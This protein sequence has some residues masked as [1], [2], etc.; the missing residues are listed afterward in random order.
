MPLVEKFKSIKCWSEKYEYLVYLGRKQQKK[1][2]DL[3]S[4]IKSFECESDM[5]YRISQLEK[6]LYIDAV[7]SSTIISGIVFLVINSMPVQEDFLIKLELINKISV[8]RYA[9]L[10]S[11]L[12]KIVSAQDRIKG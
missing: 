2:R 12:K 5:Y 10:Q 7:S 1:E 6:T 4:Y 8:K 9:G 3:S 11:F